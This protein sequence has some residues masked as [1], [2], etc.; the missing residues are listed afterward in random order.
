MQTRTWARRSASSN[1]EG[2]A[3]AAAAGQRGQVLAIVWVAVLALLLV[4][5]APFVIVIAVL[6]FGLWLG[7]QLRRWALP[8]G[9]ANWRHW[10]EEEASKQKQRQ[11]QGRKQ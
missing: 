1:G 4:L 2:V 3:G 6:A 11:Q 5:E 8:P 9:V 10:L 7:Y